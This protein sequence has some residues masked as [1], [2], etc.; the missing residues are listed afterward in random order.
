MRRLTTR[1]MPTMIL[2]LLLPLWP[3]GN[4]GAQFNGALRGDYN[5]TNFRTCQV[6]SDSGAPLGI[7]LQIAIQGTITYDGAGAGNFVGK[8]LAVNASGETPSDQT[9]SV[10]YTVNADGSFTQQ[11][12]CT[13]TFTATAATASL[14]GIQQ[15]GRLSLDGTVVLFTDTETNLEILTPISPPGTGTQRRCNSSGV[16][17]SRR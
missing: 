15:Q 16:A 11:L 17:T 4:A 1:L 6:L 2:V 14:N 9:C 10:S 13:L 3:A 7:E 12:N 8:G 5:L